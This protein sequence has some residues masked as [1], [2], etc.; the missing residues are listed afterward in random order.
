MRCWHGEGGSKHNLMLGGRIRYACFFH[1]QNFYG[2]LRFFLST[3]YSVDL[4][5]YLWKHRFSSLVRIHHFRKYL[6]CLD[7]KILHDLCYPVVVRLPEHLSR[8]AATFKFHLFM[9]FQLV[10]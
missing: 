2:G 5:I 7:H 6:A 8:T 4:L 10:H 9:Y 1:A 3:V